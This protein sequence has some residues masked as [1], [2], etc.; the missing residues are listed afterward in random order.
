MLSNWCTNGWN[1]GTLDRLGDPRD[2]R[3][4]LRPTMWKGNILGQIPNENPPEEAMKDQILN[5]N[6]P[7]EAMKDQI[8]NENPPEGA[9]KQFREGKDNGEK[10]TGGLTIWRPAPVVH[11]VRFV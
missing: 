4:D 1:L 9:M 7:E 8:P 5:E 2:T 3:T 6:P 10:S 11:L